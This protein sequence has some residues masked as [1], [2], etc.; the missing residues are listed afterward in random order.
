MNSRKAEAGILY[1]II[2]NGINKNMKDIIRSGRTGSLALPNNS[3]L[4]LYDQE[5]AQC[6]SA[7]LLPTANLNSV[8]RRHSSHCCPMLDE[9]QQSLPLGNQS[10][11]LTN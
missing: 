6:S 9:R 4:D 7:A 1:F 11:I 3:L 10:I 8:I 2:T 5:Q